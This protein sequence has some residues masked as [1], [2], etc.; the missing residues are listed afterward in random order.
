MQHQK[1]FAKGVA[2]IVVGLLILGL[3]SFS[4][5]AAS[6]FE[7]AWRIQDEKG[8]SFDM[9][10][11]ADGSA[12]ATLTKG[13]TGTWKEENGVA[14]ITWATG[15]TSKIIKE[16]DTYKSQTWAKDAPLNGPATLVWNAQKS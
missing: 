2:A 15:W 10:L 11:S 5:I 3:T 4:S 8:R 14:V 1:S 12:T 6:E 16:G 9:T 13:L 7:G